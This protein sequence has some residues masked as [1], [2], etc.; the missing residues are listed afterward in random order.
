MMPVTVTFNSKIL[1]I[2]AKLH[3]SGDLIVVRNSEWQRKARMPSCHAVPHLAGVSLPDLSATV[4][5][6]HCMPSSACTDG[7]RRLA[8]HTPVHH[9]DITVLC[10]AP[11]TIAETVSFG[12][13]VGMVV[14]LGTWWTMS[15]ATIL[16][17]EWDN[18]RSGNPSLP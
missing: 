11:L 1:Q 15:L 10:K 14:H 3:D 13:S 8:R 17:A 4:H 2:C 12:S 6:V 7:R 18:A 5:S 16:E 9:H